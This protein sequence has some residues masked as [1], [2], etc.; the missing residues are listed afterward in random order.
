MLKT[1]KNDKIEI[2]LKLND[3]KLIN[4]LNKCNFKNRLKKMQLSTTAKLI[5]SFLFS[6]ILQYVSKV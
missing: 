1:K 3:I 5:N 4:K 2:N 6:I